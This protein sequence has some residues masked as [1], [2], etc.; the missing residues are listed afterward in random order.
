MLRYTSDRYLVA[1]YN[2]WPE[3]EAGLFLQP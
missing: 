2:I 1:F 3:Y